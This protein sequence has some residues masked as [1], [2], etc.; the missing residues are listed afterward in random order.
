MCV[1]S[2]AEKVYKLYFSSCLGLAGR[3]RVSFDR[4][5]V[6]G[7]AGVGTD[8]GTGTGI[9]VS[10]NMKFPSSARDDVVVVCFC[11]RV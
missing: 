1:C 8:D 4:K 10:H 5:G 7:P 3:K 6:R 11:R 2:A 9:S